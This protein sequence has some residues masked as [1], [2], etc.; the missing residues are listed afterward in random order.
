MAAAQDLT[1]TSY[2]GHHLTNRTMS[3]GEGPFWT[4]HLDTFLTAVALGVVGFGLLWWVVRGA[5]AGV[6][7]TSYIDMLLAEVMALR[8]NLRLVEAQAKGKM[9]EDK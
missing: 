9:L 7:S 1:P 3:L 6:P 5:T 8:A 2:I 4:L